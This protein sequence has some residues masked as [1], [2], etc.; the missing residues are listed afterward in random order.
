VYGTLGT[1]AATNIP[2]SR[3]GAVTWTDSSGNFWLFGGNGD[4]AN[5][6]A[7]NLNDLWEFNPST[8]QWTW[9]S[10]SSTNCIG[11]YPYGQSSVYG[12]LGTP[13]VTN[14]PG[15]RDY[16]VSW[17]DSSGNFWL[18]GG[19]G[20]D[21]NGNLGDLSDLWEFTP[22]T[23]QWVWMGGSNTVNQ[24][25]VYGTL[26]VP[27][28]GNTP[29][30][31]DDAVSWTDS[32]G[33][34]WLFGGNGYDGNGK[35]GNLNDLWKY[36][37]FVIAATPSFSVAPGTYIA[38]QP[39]TI[40]DSTAD[41]TIYYTTD[42][43]TPTASSTVYASAIT[44]SSTETLKAIALAP[45]YSVSAMATAAYIITPPAATPTFSVTQRPYIAAQTVA[46]GDTTTGATIYYTT[47]GT[48]PT[49]SSSVYSSPIP[50]S[51]SETIEAIAAGGGY[52]ASAVATAAYTIT[53]PMIATPTFNLAA[54]TYP[55]AQT[56]TIDD[57]TSGSI[58]YYTT[59]GSTPTTSSTQ[60][61]GAI[62]VS[63]SETIQAIAAAA[64]DNNSTVASAAYTIDITTNPVPVIGGTSPAIATATGAAFKLT[65]NGTGFISGSTVYWDSAALTTTYVSATQ[66]TA[67]VTATD[68]AS[69]GTT[70]IAVQTSTPGGGTSNS[71]QFEV[72]SAASTSSGPT[73]TSTT[74]SVAAGATASYTETLPS[75][76]SSASVTC[77]NL[78][79]G[80]TCSYS[81]GTVTIATSSTTPTG[82]YQVTVVFAETVSSSSSA[83]ILVPILLLPL[84]FL[85]RKMALKNIWI[86]ACLGLV[87]MAAAA[88]SIGCGGGTASTTTTTTTTPT[89]VT[90]SA[91]VS[92]TVQ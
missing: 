86:T 43:T 6:C 89:Q 5:G 36:Q 68:I 1:P 46:I 58:I 92:L 3:I 26:G 34:L 42:G 62:T 71:W 44:V 48:T 7:G 67:A 21:A 66:L 13:A 35:I 52:S 41:A 14:M 4:D 2:G 50:V 18:L 79:T 16:A 61:T 8:N 30:G 60:Y 37:P 19:N 51:S 40:S 49:T 72:D 91:V 56:V 85:R 33:N 11:S 83:F 84:V 59:D 57:A 9:M 78:P 29:G 55:S 80:A 47:N 88:L 31:R 54:G 82:T 20:S 87:L 73:F 53:Y 45:G 10:G 27:A 69:A 39:V 75:D 15:G 32:S 74:A 23:N 28:T 76:V 70:A 38:T 64:G 25:G 24:S 63:A 65:V 77:L 12:T 17:T 22:T 81:P 90:S